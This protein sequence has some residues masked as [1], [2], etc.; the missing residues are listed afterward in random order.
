MKEELIRILNEEIAVATEAEDSELVNHL[1]IVRD[2][3]IDVRAD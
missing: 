1:T 2:Y 3:L